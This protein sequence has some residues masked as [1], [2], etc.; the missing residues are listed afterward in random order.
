MHQNYEG[1]SYSKEKKKADKNTYELIIAQCCPFA[2]FNA[3][4][5][6]ENPK[7]FKKGLQSLQYSYIIKA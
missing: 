6:I 4:K 2:Y 3:K 5:Y 7:Y 1:S